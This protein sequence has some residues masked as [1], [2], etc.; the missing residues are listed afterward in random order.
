MSGKV[1]N[2]QEILNGL[3]SEQPRSFYMINFEIKPLSEDTLLAIYKLQEKDATSLSSSIWKL[4][5][6]S[7]Q[8]IFHQGTKVV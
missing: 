8:L 7:W 4:Y 5:S 3:P 2:K 1:Y 6:G